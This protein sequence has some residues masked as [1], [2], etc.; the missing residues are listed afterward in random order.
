MVIFC[1]LTAVAQKADTVTAK[2][3]IPT[4][5]R[6]GT[7]LISLGKI[8]WSDKFDG[9]EVSADIDFYKYYLT[10]EYGDWERTLNS[11]T[12]NYSNAGN[13]FRVGPDINLLLKDPDRNMVFIGLRYAQSSFDEQLSFVTQDPVYGE[14]NE[15]LNNKGM[16]ASWGEIT[17]GLRVKVWKELWMGY[18]ARL[19]IVPIVHGNEEFIVYEI[20]G[21]G[22]ASKNTYWGFNYQIYWRFRVRH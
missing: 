8:P 22:L 2:S 16:K 1:C 12:Q 7:D 10:V 4:G 3:Y 9:W 18:T 17:M 13:Y 11:A 19:K 5:L 15:T 14:I 20:P 21:Y 6:L